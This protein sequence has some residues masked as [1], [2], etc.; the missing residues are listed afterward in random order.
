MRRDYF[1]GDA[2]AGAAIRFARY[3]LRE[4]KSGRRSGRSADAADRADFR[5]YLP[6]SVDLSYRLP[7]PGNQG[8]ASSCTA[9]ATAYAARSYYTSAYEARDTHDV[10]NVPSPAFVYNLSWRRDSRGACDGGS[11]FS[12]A[13]SVLKQGAPSL[14]DYPYRDSDCSVP[15]QETI[16][17]ASDFRVQGLRRIDQSR[18]DDVKG[19]IPGRENRWRERSSLA[20]ER[21]SGNPDTGSRPATARPVSERRRHWKNSSLR[22]R[23]RGCRVATTDYRRMPGSGRSHV[24]RIACFVGGRAIAARRI[25][26]SPGGTGRSSALIAGLGAGTTGLPTRE[27]NAKDGLDRQ[28]PKNGRIVFLISIRI[29]GI[30]RIELLRLQRRRPENN[31]AT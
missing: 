17:H 18:I 29:T 9:W 19:A 4:G 6:V 28:R 22:R 30:G 16:A 24:M 27:I 14:A 25:G 20:T 8:A 11:S 21:S 31:R 13:A 23:R 7:D 15:S 3:E 12:N 2:V 10:K 1:R 26:R 5:A